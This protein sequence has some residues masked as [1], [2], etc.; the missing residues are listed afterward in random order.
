MELHTGISLSDL[1]QITP[2]LTQEYTQ[3]FTVPFTT[4]KTQKK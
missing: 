3:A 2:K 1:V 4:N